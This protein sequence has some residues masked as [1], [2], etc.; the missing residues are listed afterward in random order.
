MQVQ[1]PS[2]HRDGNVRFAATRPSAGAIMKGSSGSI[3]A[4][5]SSARERPVSAHLARWHRNP[6]RSPNRTNTRFEV[7]FDGK[8]RVR[9]PGSVLAS[10]NNFSSV[11]RRT[12]VLRWQP[13]GD[14]TGARARPPLL[15]LAVGCHDPRTGAATVA[16]PHS[17]KRGNERANARRFLSPPACA[18]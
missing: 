15:S 3:W 12:R 11:S 5:R 10:A 7:E 8:I 14:G 13:E 9:I 4:D 18:E 17:C 6:R 2:M 16:S 1:P